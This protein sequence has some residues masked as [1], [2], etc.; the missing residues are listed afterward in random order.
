MEL[1][2]IDCSGMK[3]DPRS[4]SSM[5]RLGQDYPEFNVPIDDGTQKWAMNED[6]IR[7]KTMRYIV[8]LYDKNSPLWDMHQDFY[9]RKVAALQLVGFEIQP[10]GEFQVEIQQGIIMGKNKVVNHMIVR[11]VFLFNNPKFVML[12]GL[13][14]VYLNLSH[15]MLSATPDDKEL[16]MFKATSADIERLT[17]E[18]FGGKENVALESTLYEVLNMNKMLFRSEHIAGRIAAG[19]KPT[20][21]NPYEQSPS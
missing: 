6:E 11:Y 19:E 18:I 21:A 7:A 2:E 5:R 14:Q 15:K 20:N 9:H 17:E 10:N 13:L 4:S 8:L 1:K 12:I 16:K 3:Y